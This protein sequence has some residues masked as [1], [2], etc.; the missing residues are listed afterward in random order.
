MASAARNV[1]G[2]VICHVPK[3]GIG[4]RMLF[5]SCRREQQQRGRARRRWA[6]MALAV[7]AI[8]IVQPGSAL[9]SQS[10][11]NGSTGDWSVPGNWTPAGVPT[12][13]ADVLLTNDIN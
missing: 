12:A 5:C 3:R 9:G 10:T 6:A 2:G 1:P 7:A 8:P 4:K 13:G 11:W